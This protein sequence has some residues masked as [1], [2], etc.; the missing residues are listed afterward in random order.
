MLLHIWLPGEET[1]ALFKTFVD[2][3]HLGDAAHQVRS[4]C[5]SNKAIKDYWRPHLTAQEQRL[6]PEEHCTE[7]YEQHTPKQ[8]QH[9]SRDVKGADRPAFIC[10]IFK[11][12][13]DARPL[14][15]KA[16]TCVWFLPGSEQSCWEHH[17]NSWWMPPRCGSSMEDVLCRDVSMNDLPDQRQFLFPSSHLNA[18][19]H[20]NARV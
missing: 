6:F 17:P 8:K 13:S 3:G 16:F 5:H 4:E 18:W 14:S 9:P 11:R 2:L 15:D 19:P 20:F 10:K 12:L 1:S 7:R